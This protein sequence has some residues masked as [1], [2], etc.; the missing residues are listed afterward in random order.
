MKYTVIEV[1][2]SPYALNEDIGHSNDSTWHSIDDHSF[3]HDLLSTIVARHTAVNLAGIHGYFIQLQLTRLSLM[4]E[5][6]LAK[7]TLR[8]DYNYAQT[9]CTEWLW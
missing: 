5:F 1:S 9:L 2:Y 6:L 7:P 8:Y 3:I 4:C